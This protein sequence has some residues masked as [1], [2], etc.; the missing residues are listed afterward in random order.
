MSEKKNYNEFFK[1]Q[2]LENA[3]YSSF[4]IEEFFNN[5]PIPDECLVK[6]IL[7]NCTRKYRERKSRIFLKRC[8]KGCFTQIK[9]NAFIVNNKIIK[10]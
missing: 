9:G 8:R 7:D 2:I 10:K 5:E 1:N 3:Y 6:K 4:E